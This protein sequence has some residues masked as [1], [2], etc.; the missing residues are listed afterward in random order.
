MVV[1][2]QNTS[3]LEH[4]GK[5]KEKRINLGERK[6]KLKETK[7]LQGN[8]VGNEE[9][10]SLTSNHSRVLALSPSPSFPLPSL[11]QWQ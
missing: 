2:G 4:I 10:E 11:P 9:G 6:K 3:L 7:E 8:G 5:S 1:R